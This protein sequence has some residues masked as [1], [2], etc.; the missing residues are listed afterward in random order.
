MAGIVRQKC[1]A[2]GADL[3]ESSGA[4]IPLCESCRMR[5]QDRSSPS[6]KASAER[7]GATAPFAESTRTVIL[8]NS[9]DTEPD[10][11]QLAMTLDFVPSADSTEP[12]VHATDARV[13]NKELVG[14]FRVISILGRGSFGTI[15]RAYDPL[16]DREVA[17]KVPRFAPDDRE[18]T[19]RFHREAKAA[20]RL[21]HPNIVTLYEHGQTDEGPYLVVE[22]VDGKPLSQLLR[23]QPVD[24]HVAVDWVRQI[25]EGLDYAHN[26]GIVHRDVKPSNIMMNHASRPQLMD[27]GLAKRDADVEAGMTMEGQIIGTPNYMSPEQA[28]GAISEIGPHSDQYSVGV[29][30]YEMLCGRPPFS[31]DPWTIIARV[32]NVRENPPSPRSVKP[33][34]PRDLEACVLK[35][36]EKDPHARYSNMQ[37]L[38]DDLDHWLK[39]LPLVARPIGP[40]EQFVRWCRHNQL[41][42]G[43]GGTVAVMLLLA[44]T[45]GPWLAV[46]FRELAKDAKREARDA[47][48]A[49]ELEKTARLATERSIIDSYTEI[50]LT[51]HRN[52]DPREAILWFANAVAASENYP[53][54]ERHNRIRMRSWLPQIAIPVQAFATTPAW[55][56][57]LN[58][59]PSGHWLLSL[60]NTYECELLQVSDGQHLAIPMPG[61]I[62]AAMFSPD[63]TRLIVAV[64]RDVA[65][66]EFAIDAVDPTSDRPDVGVRTTGFATKELDRW[67]HSET[68]RCLQFS[69]DGELL[70]VGGNESVQVREIPMKTF[71]TGSFTLGSQVTSAAIAADGRRFAVRC[72]DKRVRVFSSAPDQANS[73]PLLPV[74]PSASDGFVPPMFVG[75][76][77]LVVIDSYKSV[78][79]WNIDTQA[80]VWEYMPKRVLTSAMSPDGKWIALGED[81]DGVLLD[82]VTGEPVQQRIKH[83]NLINNFSFHP[84]RSLL[85]TACVDHSARIFEI[86]SG[87][88]VGLP[89]PHGDAVHRCLW[90]PDGATFA[91]VHWTGDLIRIWKPSDPRLEEFVAAPSARGPFVRL[92]D[93]GDR[94]IPSSFD[95]GRDRTEFE[96]CDVKTGKVIGPKLSGPGLIS[97][98]DF[99]PVVGQVSNLPSKDGQ[100]G[101]LPHVVLV[102]GGSRDDVYRSLPDQKLDSSGFV[103]FVNSETGEPAFP[104]VTTSS[105]PIAVR[106]APDGRTVVVLCHQGH[107]LLLDSATGKLHAEYQAFGGQPA[108]HG[109]LIRDR[110]RFSE[111]G[112]QFLIWG[113]GSLAELRKTDTGELLAAIHHDSS[114]IHDAQF[115]PDSKLVATC[116]SDNSVC[117]WDSATGLT[118]GKPL[119]HSGWVFSAQ[120]SRDGRRLLTASED[121]QARIWDMA[122]RTAILTTREHGDQVFGVS[123]LPGEEMF[124]ASTR[125]GQITAW[126]AS[127]GKM[128]APSRQMPGMVYQ[129]SR[130]GTVPW[131]IASGQIIPMRGFN[132]TQWILEPDTQLSR[133]DVRLLG[134]LLASQ[135]IHESG[136]A[137]SLTSAEWFEHWTKFREKHPVHRVLKA[138]ATTR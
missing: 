17:L 59:H 84:H 15:Y 11:P 54:R 101:N 51:A 96:V 95:G 136:A 55:K 41:L 98:A 29:V 19:E 126:D 6:S 70:V 13:A 24:I 113:C 58:Y 9:G 61:Q 62:T 88:P 65:V 86:P 12:T 110:L 132:W 8:G 128:I 93:H 79:C 127:L 69:A 100:V 118:S 85:L 75:N 43:L 18:M 92:N 103:R 109:F 124:L 50:G 105:Q 138:P 57:S 108:I 32:A 36:M 117:L 71:R 91:T 121:K 135:R 106:A 30:L 78:R 21:H 76:D 38:A 2:C 129:L 52:G 130:Q 64:N 80:I 111:Q 16:L 102:G 60:S 97:D 1:S 44:A 73:E 56:Q 46:R 7:S 89:I 72:A 34:L 20:A 120:F 4:T 22:F 137:T 66:F 74:L 10:Q 99:V 116:S 104:D 134:E 27:F 125:D 112:D 37:T 87:K 49:R 45:I 25:A 68:V 31:G 14:R 94:W 33:D 35:A 122:T 5:S 133:E 67:T 82:A 131:V 26:E 114:F 123:F 39:G 115:S 28:R 107:L 48:T 119:V 63:G 81:G 90:S 40:L 23:E 47:E 42:A 53:L 77:R 3:A 83:P